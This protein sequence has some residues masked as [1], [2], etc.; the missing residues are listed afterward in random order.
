MGFVVTTKTNKKA[1]DL[2]SRIRSSDMKES[3]TVGVH[4]D[5]ARSRAEPGGPTNADIA[6]WMEFGDTKSNRPPPPRPWLRPVMIANKK[7]YAKVLAD[8]IKKHYL[9][10]LKTSAEVLLMLGQIIVSDIR[11]N[12]LRG[13]PP[14][15]SDKYV[16]TKRKKGMARPDTPLFATGAF[17][18][19][20][21]PKVTK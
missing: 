10:G 7:I 18:N 17:F 4:Q 19:A 14:A 20:I 13:I 8:L 6:K 11:K 1:K 12:I 9:T 2:L 16:A 5:E 3:L 15:L 21:K